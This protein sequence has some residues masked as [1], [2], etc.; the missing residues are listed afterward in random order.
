MGDDSI[1]HAVITDINR[2]RA[3]IEAGQAD[4][5]AAVKPAYK[6]NLI[7][8]AGRCRNRLAENR[9]FCGGLRR[10]AIGFL[11]GVI[12]AD[13]ANVRESETDDLI[14]VRWVSQDFLIPRHGGVK[15]HA[16]DIDQVS[17]Q[18]TLCAGQECEAALTMR[19]A[20]VKSAAG[21]QGSIFSRKHLY[22]PIANAKRF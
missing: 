21:L 19:A 8:V 15:A 9:A 20:R 10:F 5:I 16:S 4:N 3:G 6:V 22:M 17:A 1:L 18:A 12:G 2:Q 11:V 14:G 13:I 7:A